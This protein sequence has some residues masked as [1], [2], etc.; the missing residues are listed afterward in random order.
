MGLI[1]E[2]QEG[3]PRPDGGRGDEAPGEKE[4]PP[5][6]SRQPEFSSWQVLFSSAGGREAGRDAPARGWAW[7]HR[8]RG[9][10]RGREDAGLCPRSRIPPQALLSADEP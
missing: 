3:Q 5:Q 9:G 4:E 1:Q 6:R 8:G 2:P 10:C 7:G